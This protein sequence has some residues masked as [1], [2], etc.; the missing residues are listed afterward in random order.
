M[1]KRFSGPRLYLPVTTPWLRKFCTFNDVFT[2]E[3]IHNYPFYKLPNRNEARMGEKIKIVAALLCAWI[4]RETE[5]RHSILN[6]VE[7][8]E[9]MELKLIKQLIVE[10]IAS[11]SE[12]SWKFFEEQR[13]KSSLPKH[14]TNLIF[15]RNEI[16]KKEVT[17]QLLL[18]ERPSYALTN[19]Q[20]GFQTQSSESNSPFAIVPG[21]HD[22]SMKFTQEGKEQE[23]G[24]VRKSFF[25]SSPDTDKSMPIKIPPRKQE[26]LIN[27]V[28]NEPDLDHVRIAEDHNNDPVEAIEFENYVLDPKFNT[29][30]EQQEVAVAVKNVKLY[31]DDLESI[32]KPVMLNDRVINWYKELFHTPDN[33]CLDT[34]FVSHTESIYRY[35]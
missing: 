30:L 15:P 7:D 27:E 29:E 35:S 19:K 6:S 4:A 24:Q 31:V 13:K 3:P 26:E 28:R 9:G 12:E 17:Q 20:E 2:G 14:E 33:L 23:N 32:L 11:R 8:V 21:V 1:T 18:C 34:S 16:T 22:V 25:E 5:T 10:C